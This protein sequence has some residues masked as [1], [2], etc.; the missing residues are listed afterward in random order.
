MLPYVG[1]KQTG[2]KGKMEEVDKFTVQPKSKL[3]ILDKKWVNALLQICHFEQASALV[4]IT[5]KF[6]N[7]HF[8]SIV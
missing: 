3:K 4:L 7:I 5:K 6:V 1:M 8:S 2:F